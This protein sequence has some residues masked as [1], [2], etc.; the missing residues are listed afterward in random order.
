MGDS[1]LTLS[2]QYYV[3]ANNWADLE[4][5]ASMLEEC[6]SAVMAQRQSM[7]GDIPVNRAEQI[8]KAS[9]EWM[10]YLEKMVKSREAANRAKI[11]LEYLKMKF[12]E[13]S[14]GQANARAEARL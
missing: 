9:P 14:S 11:K 6:K 8:V 2:E 3:A 12:Q 7:L 1:N 5:A 13:W 4:S 10:E